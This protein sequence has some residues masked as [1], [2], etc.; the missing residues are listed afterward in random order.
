MS[1]PVPAPPAGGASIAARFA[2]DPAV[3]GHP[4]VRAA[5]RIATATLEPHAA[6]ADDPAR[7]VDPAHL[8]EL[9]RHR[10]L[11]IAV[12]IAEGGHGADARI[13]AEVVEHLSGGCGATWFVTTQ[14]RFPQ[15]LSR[16]VLAGM[17]PDAVTHGPA[18]DR[19]RPALC[20]ADTL[21]GIAIAHIR[22]PGPPAVRA[23]PAG[24]GWTL[25][26][27]ADWCTGWGL[28]DLVMV[29]AST[30]D[31]RFV[32]AMV[33]ARDQPGLRAS[34]PLP[35]SV[36]GGT[37]TVALRMDGLRVAADDVLVTVDVAAWRAHDA[38]RTTN[39]TPATFG[40]LRRMLGA[41]AE[42]GAARDR[43]AAVELAHLLAERVLYCRDE[44]YA[45]LTGVPTFE[46]VAQRAALRGE[47]AEL[48]VRTAHAV[49]AT[50][51]GSAL[52]AGSPEQRWAREA[53]F[54]LIQAQTDRVRAAQLAA[55]G[56]STSQLITAQNTRK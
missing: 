39:T 24:T 9:V 16:G 11:G 40:L 2:A 35:L 44:A 46:R 14:H 41:L 28:L 53:G 51:A 29:A 45:L 19:L 49:I 23:E 27:A 33:P 4:A 52:L 8:A 36:M 21:A 32:L 43:P 56:R 10:L 18:A 26:G 34:A 1:E 12:P 20:T 38:A 22:R 37:R 50:R 47:V 48:A 3:D 5:A 42:L 54:H 55:F 7:G 13:D 31:D 25:H 17:S 15:A 6:A 30:P